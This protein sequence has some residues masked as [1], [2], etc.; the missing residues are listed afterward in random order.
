MKE[1][2]QF[3]GVSPDALKKS[4]KHIRAKRQ[5][6]PYP[7]NFASITYPDSFDVTQQWPQC[8]PLITQ[9]QNQAHCGNCWAVSTAEVITDRRCIT[10]N[11]TDLERT[12]AWDITC[13]CPNC[14]SSGQNDGCHGGSPLDAFQYYNTNGVVSGNDNPYAGTA[15]GFCKPYPL[16]E[17]DPMPSSTSC[18]ATCQSAYTANSYDGDKVMGSSYFPVSF[19]D[20]A[21][22]Y[23]LM[24]RGPVVVLFAVY[25][26]FYGKDYN[27]W[28][29]D[30]NYGIFWIGNLF[31]L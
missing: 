6:F 18:S 27:F 26:D 8:N 11:T 30:K 19:S 31:I 22:M 12:S 28:K 23:E 7:D 29:L 17:S 4:S 15:N 2:R 24:T 25:E 14:W 10:F 5:T 13:C 9:I 21:V 3:L 16:S 20:N 1:L